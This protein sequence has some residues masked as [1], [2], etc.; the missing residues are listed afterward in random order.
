MVAA[1]C[2]S[3]DAEGTAPPTTVAPPVGLDTFYG[4]PDPLPDGRPGDLLSY[5]RVYVDGLQGTQWRVM[6]LS[7]SIMGDPVVVTGVVLVPES[8]A[9]D[10]GRV[11]V[12]WAHGTEGLA[13]ECAPSIDPSKVAQYAT[14]LLD[15]GW[16]VTATDYE[17]L[18]TPGRHP[19]LVGE[20]E[21]R[22]VLDIVKAA[23]EIPEAELGDRYVVW[24]HSQ[25]GH[26]A[27]FAGE[28]AEEWAPD[29][30]LVGVVSGA[31]PSQLLALNAKL[32][33]TPFKHYV[34]MSVA[35]L[36][37]GYGDDR[38]P[39]DAVL[40]A[41]GISWLANVD[42]LCSLNLGVAAFVVDFDRFETADPADVPAWRSIIEENDPGRFTDPI[43]APLLIVH[44]DADEQIPADSSDQ[45]LEQL[46]AI[47]QVAER[48][49][50]PGANHTSVVR[51]SYDDMV[52][53]IA[54]R[55]DGAAPSD[56]VVPAG[57]PEPSTQSCNLG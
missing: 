50:F 26:A 35:G 33:T 2:T 48:W 4:V 1:A 24:G 5:E 3:D 34:A 30:E 19:Y 56:A 16:V 23:H 9:P 27:L 29:L 44:G 12:S 20:S 17:G 39:L 55:V 45:L 8:P 18:G 40:N 7:E 14:P 21:G 57:P 53:W 13:D 11:A 42:E 32:Q 51:E 25:G 15:H 38:A 6:Y 10:G 22:G 52:R 28:I 46:C 47:G 31:P 36:N 43:P 49:V 54:D 37:A 41:E